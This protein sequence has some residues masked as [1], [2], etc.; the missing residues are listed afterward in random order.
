MT[1]DELNAIATA[2]FKNNNLYCGQQGATVK[3]LLKFAQSL[4]DSGKVVEAEKYQQ[5]FDAYKITAEY[6]HEAGYEIDK[7]SKSDKSTLSSAGKEVK[8]AQDLSDHLIHDKLSKLYG[9]H[10]TISGYKSD[11]FMECINWLRQFKATP[12]KVISDEEIEGYIDRSLPGWRSDA[13][14]TGKAYAMRSMAKWYRDQLKAK[15][16]G[17]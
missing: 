5:M 16:D 10:H 17:N 4:I 2:F 15:H 1:E 11:G 8:T 3:Y 14:W 13:S 6:L 7:L 12:V 9:D